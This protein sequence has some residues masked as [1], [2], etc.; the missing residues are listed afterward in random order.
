M[1]KLCIFCGE[2]PNNKT[3]EHI[4]P[5]WLI[6]MTGKQNR[7]TQISVKNGKS[8]NF[9]WM[10]YTFP[11]CDACNTRYSSLEAKVKCIMTNLLGDKKFSQ[12][13]IVD[14]LDWFDKVRVGIWL[15]KLIL[16]QENFEP[17]FHINQ[18]IGTSDRFL[19]ISRSI[20]EV[21]GITI[22]GTESHAFTFSPTC[23]ALTINHLTFISCSSAFLL[24]KNMGFPYAD[25]LTY[26][27]KSITINKM[28]AGLQNLCLPLLPTKVVSPS[29]KM[30]QT[31]LKSNSDSNPN[32]DDIFSNDEVSIRSSKYIIDNSIEYNSSY[33]LSK[34]FIIKDTERKYFGFLNNDELLALNLD[35]EH[36]Y[37]EMI[38]LPM[39]ATIVF[40]HQNYIMEKALESTINLSNSKKKDLVNFYQILIKNNKKYIDDIE[41]RIDKYAT[42]VT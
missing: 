13:D 40:S 28:L 41:A 38:L 15:G 27:E 19:I 22:T 11:A 32:T 23:F 20:E 34:P 33:L 42:I 31:I 16:K 14:L 17:N 4:I 7:V 3:K 24:T 1:K 9:P 35:L 21:K 25:I 8:I 18:R 26:Q 5:Q 12:T 29:V 6:K 10:K 39:V 2:K 36:A 30:Y 37:P